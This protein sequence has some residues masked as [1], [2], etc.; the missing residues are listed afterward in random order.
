MAPPSSEP[1]N[2]CE[3]YMGLHQKPSKH[4]SELCDVSRVMNPSVS[5]LSSHIPT[6]DSSLTSPACENHMQRASRMQHR[7]TKK[8]SAASHPSRISAQWRPRAA[9]FAGRE[10]SVLSKGLLFF[11]FGPSQTVQNRARSSPGPPNAP[12]CG[13]HATM[14]PTTTARSERIRRSV[15]TTAERRRVLSAAPGAT[16]SHWSHGRCGR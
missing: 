7:G 16:G 6:H 2:P 9:S 5:E 1:F 4:S 12:C 10:S 15:S 13:T 8:S 14:L 3:S 11:W